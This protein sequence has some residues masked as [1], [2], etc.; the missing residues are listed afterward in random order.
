MEL[1]KILHHD[2]MNPWPVEDKSINCIVTSP[3]Y[4]ALRDYG[5]PGQLGL[6]K[7]PEEFI[8]NMVKVFREAKR[9]LRDDGTLWVNIGDS[10]AGGGKKR[11]K[12][13]ATAK[14]TIE[15]GLAGQ[16]QSLVQQSKIVGDIK[17]K[18]LVGIPWMLAFALRQ[19]YVQ[20]EIKTEADR[21]WMAGIVDGEGC[22]TIVRSKS[23]HC[24]SYSF[25]PSIQVR[26]CDVEPMQKL[27][28]IVGSTYGDQQLPPSYVAAGQKPAYQWKIVSQRAAN[29]I[30]EI[31]PFL[32]CKKKQ[33]IVA[34]N[35]QQFRSARGNGERKNGELEKEI[36]CKELIN[37]LNQREPVDIPSWMKEPI[38]QMEPGWYLRQDLIWHKPNPMPE[39]TRDRCTKSHEYL[40]MFSKKSQY[41]YDFESI[42]TPAVE[43]SLNPSHFSDGTKKE[44]LMRQ[45]GVS[46]KQRGHSRRH[47][48]FNDRWDNMTVEEQQSMGANKRSVWTV[49]TSDFKEAHFATF[50]PDLI[51]DC[52][53]A[54]CPPGGTVLDPF[55]GAGTTALVA[56][57]LGRN[58]LGLELNPAYIEMAEKRLKND[59]GMFNLFTFPSEGAPE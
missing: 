41:Y 53:K 46:D 42:K 25:P 38:K 2:V 21:A 14:S 27:V 33:A 26:M 56:A 22:I 19:P 30:E 40:F 1:N 28:N 52:I 54:G 8:A 31:Y 36:L 48:G 15:G 12:Q 43:H 49:P 7:A 39:S 50:P 16:Y 5:V 58:Y 6:E 18:D 51:V 59:L 44:A 13:Q 37:K 45:R 3:P 55:M 9:V 57:K 4:W 32:T 23:S 17:A 24:E 11:T 10:Y 20:W 34:W 47:A 35:H 29:I